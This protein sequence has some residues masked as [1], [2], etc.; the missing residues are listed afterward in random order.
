MDN[1]DHRY[2]FTRRAFLMGCGKLVLSTALIG[3][4]YYLQ[5]IRELHYKNLADENRL[6]IQFLSPERGIIRDINGKQLCVNKTIFKAFMVPD[7]SDNWEDTLKQVQKILCLPDHEIEAIRNHVL[8]KYRFMPIDLRES[9][10]WNKVSTLSLAA[11]DLPGVYVEQMLRRQYPYG[12]LFAHLLGYVQRPSQTD[13]IERPFLSLPDYHMGKTGLEKLYDLDLRGQI[14]LQEVEVNARHRPVRVLSK[15]LPE[16]GQRK[17]LTLNVDLQHY[18]YEKLSIFE[19]AASVLI[20]LDTGGIEAMVSIPSFDPNIFVEGV[21]SSAWQELL[22]NEYKP[23]NFRVIQGTYPPASTFKMITALAAFYKGVLT[24]EMTFHC[25]GKFS[26]GDHTFHCW[27]KNGHGAMNVVEAIAQSCDTFF[28]HLAQRVGVDT[29][30]YIARMFG[31]GTLS[32]LN[33]LGEQEGLVPNKAWKQKIFHRPWYQ[34]ETIN[35]AIGQGYL[36]STPLQMAIMTA[37]IATEEKVI[38]CLLKTKAK[39]NFEY[40][41]DPLD[42]KKSHLFLVKKGME[43]AIHSPMGT[44]R[45]FKDVFPRMG[46]KTGTAQV[47]HISLA[48]RKKGVYKNDGLPR[49]LRDHALYIG[50]A[51]FDAPKYALSVVIEH[52]GSGTRVAAP[53]GIDILK[54]A[55][56]KG[57]ALC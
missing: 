25:T 18:V 7:D 57:S 50:F 47:R 5:F 9:L 41:F 19:S 55:L 43:E 1:S 28:Y 39:K 54:Y 49:H 44:A 51:P 35:L 8:H 48:E 26:L 23:L 45:R 3:R 27:R 36:K 12:P 20:N 11:P 2:I 34:G 21:T 53:V 17:D 56:K 33:L 10:D 4:L 14:G 24:P 52:G 40:G 16:S 22:Q 32:Q 6:K 31:F 15:I 37:R 46:G 42:L 29:I 38:P 13:D 30:S